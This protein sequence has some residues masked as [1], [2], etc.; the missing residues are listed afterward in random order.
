MKLRIAVLLAAMS[1]S[2]AA[3]A[4][5]TNPT[6]QDGPEYA[7]KPALEAGKKLPLFWKSSQTIKTNR[8]A[9]STKLSELALAIDMTLDDVKPQDNKAQTEGKL[10][11]KRLFGQ[12]EIIGEV[13]SF[14]T[15]KPETVRMSNDQPSYVLRMAQRPAAVVFDANGKV[16]TFQADPAMVKSLTESFKDFKDKD[17]KLK[18]VSE[19][20]QQLA[21]EPFAYLPIA[22]VKE[23]A[24][25]QARKKVVYLD[26]TG[27]PVAMDEISDCTLLRVDQKANGR[28]ALIQITGKCS[29]PPQEGDEELAEYDIM[30][31]M[32]VNL[33][34]ATQL[35]WRVEVI[36]R[37]K[38]SSISG[39]KGVQHTVV[40]E[41][42]CGEQASKAASQPL[43]KPT[44]TAKKD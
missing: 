2:Q 25:W 10:T 32:R 4:Q 16:T 27:M 13:E 24:C 36:R 21:G 38:T 7:F 40:N 42:I 35:R 43:S 18:A 33:D 3:W 19:M 12:A 1:L 14:D 22:A 17:D 39:A 6:T 34:D 29:L 44:V 20:M 15:A 5:A 28:V 26:L 31:A 41:L 9:S 8:E 30:G 23:G 11:L 37:V